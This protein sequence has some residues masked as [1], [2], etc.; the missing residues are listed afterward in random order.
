[1]AIYPGKL[2]EIGQAAQSD[3][4]AKAA[5]LSPSRLPFQEIGV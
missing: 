5:I 4:I 1:V 2:G 3:E